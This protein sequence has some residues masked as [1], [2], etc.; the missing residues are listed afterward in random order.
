VGRR[1]TLIAGM[2]VATLFVAYP[3]LCRLCPGERHAWWLPSPPSI[4]LRA[5]ASGRLVTAGWTSALAKSTRAG[6]DA[7]LTTGDLSTRQAR[8]SWRTSSISSFTDWHGVAPRHAPGS[9]GHRDHKCTDNKQEWF[10]I[11]RRSVSETHSTRAPS[12][13]VVISLFNSRRRY[14]SAGGTRRS[15][16]GRAVERGLI[17][18]GGRRCGGRSTRFP[19]PVDDG[20]W[21]SPDGRG[22]PRSD[23]WCRWSGTGGSAGERVAGGCNSCLWQS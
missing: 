13:A 1:G 17:R 11:K 21:G 6:R 3:L 8:R 9:T 4:S 16:F 7:N 10:V 23:L 15:L 2:A 5:R 19:I 20:C 12:P 18:H 14:P 22:F